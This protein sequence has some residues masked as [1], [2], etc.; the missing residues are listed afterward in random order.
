MAPGVAE[1][2][3]VLAVPLAGGVLKLKV[4]ATE[5][6]G[7]DWRRIRFETSPMV[8][9]AER[10]SAPARGGFEGWRSE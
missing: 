2:G 9:Y 4:V 1:R 7:P 10:K 8:P 3:N 5:E 6:A